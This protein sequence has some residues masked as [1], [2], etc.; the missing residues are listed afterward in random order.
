MADFS[1]GVE[2][3]IHA[4]ATVRVHFPVDFAGNA[5]VSCYQ[6]P[7]FSRS[8]CIC[9]LTKQVVNYPQKYVGTECPLEAE[10]EQ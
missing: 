2:R 7:Y 5:D 1:S 10:D 4:K 3:Y 6:C 8:P 9:Q